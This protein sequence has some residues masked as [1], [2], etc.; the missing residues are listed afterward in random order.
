MVKICNNIGNNIPGNHGQ[1]II[2][3][4][5]AEQHSVRDQRRG[6][7]DIATLASYLV[8][9]YVALLVLSKHPTT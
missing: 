5:D 1:F 8:G 6:K 3:M 7:A 2:E 9:Y 4:Q